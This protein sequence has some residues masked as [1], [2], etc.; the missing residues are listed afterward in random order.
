MWLCYSA[1]FASGWGKTD[2]QSRPEGSTYAVCP[3]EI[4]LLGR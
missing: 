3:Q 2:I 1:N 4:K